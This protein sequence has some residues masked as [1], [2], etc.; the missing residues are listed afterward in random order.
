MPNSFLPANQVDFV[1]WLATFDTKL[2]SY[3]T[4]LN[5]TAAEKA[6][7]HADFIW[8]QFA[9]LQADLFK[10]EASER[11]SFR[12][13]LRHGPIGTPALQTPELQSITFPAG[14]PVPPGIEPRI[15]ALVQR[16]KNHSNYTETIGHD[17]DIITP[18]TATPENPKPIGRADALPGCCAQVFYPKGGFDGALVESR[19]GNETDWTPLGLKLRNNFVDDRPPLVAGQPEVRTYKLRYQKG[20]AA[21]GVWSDVFSA[22]VSP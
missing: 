13:T 19:R 6:S 15:R 10:T 11:L 1:N 4:V 17:L 21:V 12:D 2:N 9:V 8:A 5:I 14:A 22:T 20:D 3:L 16:I 18:E 7:V